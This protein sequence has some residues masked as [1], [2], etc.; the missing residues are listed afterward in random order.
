M[1]WKSFFSFLFFLF[2]LVTLVIYWFLPY[3]SKEFFISNEF[4]GNSNFNLENGSMTQFYPNMRFPTSQISYNINNGCTLQKKADME[5]AFEIV[6]DKTVLSFYPVFSDEEISIGCSN[7]N[8]V[9][10][11][12]F[13]AGEGGPTN[14]TKSGNYNIIFNGEILL[15]RDSQCENPN[16]GIHELFHVLGF[17]HSDN[18]NNIMYSV[19]KCNQEISQDMIDLIYELYSVSSEPDLIFE[20]VSAQMLGKYLGTEFTIR[21]YGLA[22]ADKFEIEIYAD[23]KIIKTVYSEEIPIG[24]GRTISLSN[25]LV[26]QF[27]VDKIELIIKSNFS[28]LD[29]ENNKISLEVNK[30]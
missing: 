8:Q 23:N 26:P 30:N 11:G 19:S 22:D 27:S 28:E 15:L 25:V 7:K 10:G 12:L 13:I 24:F 14:I 6:S 18:P 29:K 5:R 20:E 16:V 1:G 21:N 2:V 17:N 3:N 9:E 4:K